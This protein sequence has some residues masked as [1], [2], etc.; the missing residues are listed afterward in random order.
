M[1][2]EFEAEGHK[3]LEVVPINDIDLPKSNQQ[4]HINRYKNREIHHQL[5]RNQIPDVGQGRYT[6]NKFMKSEQNH[7]GNASGQNH[8]KIDIS[9]DCPNRPLDVISMESNQQIKRRND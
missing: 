8:P 4:R 2:E 5:E 6:G 1:T 7:E 9:Q 3:P